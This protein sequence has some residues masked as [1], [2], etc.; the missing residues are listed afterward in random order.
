MIT[1]TTHRVVDHEATHA[2]LGHMLGLKVV[3]ITRTAPLDSG[4]TC[5]VF[6]DDDPRTNRE[7]AFAWCVISIGAVWY[8]SGLV[9]GKATFC[10]DSDVQK[11]Q[12]LA[13]GAGFDLL[14]A[15]AYARDLCASEQ[16]RKLHSPLTDVMMHKIHLDER[17]LAKL[18]R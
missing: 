15:S 18:L 16:F 11:A 12:L 14:D 2:V 10:S 4:E 17:E 8:E 6:R 9:G 5:S 7:R 3:S 13:D 1:E